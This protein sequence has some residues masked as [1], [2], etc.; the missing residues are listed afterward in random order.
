MSPAS[1]L[2]AVALSAGAPAARA[3]ESSLVLAEA[4]Y[5][6]GDFEKALKELESVVSAVSTDELLGRAHILEGQCHSAMEDFGKTE[7]AFAKALDHD[8]EIRL[9]P[10]RV[11]P[12]LVVLLDSL[13]ARMTAE[14]RLDSD[15]AG[16][17]AFLDGKP[18]GA[19]PSKLKVPIG[20]HR[21][22]V[23]SADGRFAESRESVFFPNRAYDWVLKLAELRAAHPTDLKG[24]VE[25]LKAV[26][27]EELRGVRPNVDARAMLDVGKGIGFEVGAG[28]SGQHLGVSAHVVLGGF[29]GGT[30]R[31][32][33]RLPRLLSLL[34]VYGSIDLPVFVVPD[35]DRR[36]EGFA[37]AVGGSAGLELEAAP[38]VA[39]FAELAGRKFVQIPPAAAQLPSSALLLG[40]GARLRLP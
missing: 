35:A 11:P 20:K 22:E 28:I 3:P 26:A 5:G 21:I 6:E 33:V 9:D 16:A 24:S 7:A 25:S 18:V 34:G 38:W 14:L 40:T 36:G 10:R 29:I 30:V 2:L 17:T 15:H 12:T 32:I 19:L 23:K 31:G 13:R 1:L 27:S 8:P 39:L 4:A 37:I